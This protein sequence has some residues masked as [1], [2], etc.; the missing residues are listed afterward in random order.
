MAS[1]F[2]LT[3]APLHFYRLK[4]LQFDW[5]TNFK[6][7]PPDKDSCVIVTVYNHANYTVEVTCAQPDSTGRMRGGR[8]DTIRR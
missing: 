4:H 8:A 6:Y 3:L 1:L 7:S 5:E 2:Q